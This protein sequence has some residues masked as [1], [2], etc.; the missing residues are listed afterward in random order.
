VTNK[1]PIFRTKKQY[2]APCYAYLEM[3][4]D[5][6]SKKKLLIVALPIRFFLLPIYHVFKV[7]R[8]KHK[9][10]RRQNRTENATAAPNGVCH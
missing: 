10:E 6:K 4:L 2:E 1:W 8:K 7:A 5:T 3:F 9:S